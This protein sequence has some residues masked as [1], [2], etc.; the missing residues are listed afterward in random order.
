MFQS[1]AACFGAVRGCLPKAVA[2]AA[3][4]SLETLFWELFMSVRNLV[5]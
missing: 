3:A 2:Q 1:S 5:R 4:G